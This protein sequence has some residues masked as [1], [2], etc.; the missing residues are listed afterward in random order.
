MRAADFRKVFSA[1]ILASDGGPSDS[2]RSPNR[3]GKPVVHLKIICGWSRRDDRCQN[4]YSLLSKLDKENFL[5]QAKISFGKSTYIERNGLILTR[6]VTSNL[7]YLC[8]V[9]GPT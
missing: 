4:T 9:N 2:E 7:E 5:D 1:A 8:I 6:E 3:I